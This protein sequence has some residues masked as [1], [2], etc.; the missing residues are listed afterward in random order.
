MAAVQMSLR[1]HHVVVCEQREVYARNRYIGVYKEVTHLMAA[2]GMPERMT[3]DFS[4][5]RGKHGIMLA[6]I[7]TLLHG[8]ALKLGV[9]IY[10]GAVA[11]GLDLETLRAGEV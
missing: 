10:T 5:Y 9:V 7:Q 2:L 8:V 4:Q 3:Y 6:D 11:R 1:D